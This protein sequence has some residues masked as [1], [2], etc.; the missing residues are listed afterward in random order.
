M[1]GKL[2]KKL[3][4]EAPLMTDT[5]VLEETQIKAALFC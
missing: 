3:D 5:E 1:E 2:G 4:G